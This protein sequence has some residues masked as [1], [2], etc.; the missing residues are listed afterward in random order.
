MNS[1]RLA[2]LS[3][4]LALPSPVKADDVDTKQLTTGISGIG[5]PGLPGT[6][7]VF[8]TEAFTVVAAPSK[9]GGADPVVA[10]GRL[11]K[12][13]VVAFGHEGYFYADALKVADT[14]AFLVNALK[15][16]GRKDGNGLKVATHG[17]PE[18]AK[19]LDGVNVT[20]VGGTTWVDKL[21]GFAVVVVSA[22]R[23]SKAET[24]SLRKFVEA[25]GGLIAGVPGWGWLQVN[26]G[27]T[28]EADFAIQKLFSAAGVA[29]SD[30]TAERPKDGIIPVTGPASTLTNASHALAALD[31]WTSG[32]PTPT[33]AEADLIRGAV[34]RLRGIPETEA[35][36]LRARLAKTLDA[37]APKL[38]VPMPKKPVG[39]KDATGKLLLA[40]STQEAMR[41]HPEETKPHPAAEAFPGSVPADAPRVTRKTTVRLGL[42]GYKCDGVGTSVN[43]RL[44]HSTGLYAAPGELVKVTLPAGAPAGLGVRI[45]SHS[46]TLW[47]LNSW[48][49]APEISREFPLA[50]GNTTPAANPFG[51]LIYIT[52]PPSAE[53]SAVEVTIANAVEAPLFVLGQTTAA[54]WETIRKHPAPWAEFASGKIVIT[55]PS[56]AARKVADPVELM[57]F[58]DAVLD[59]CADLSVVPRERGRAERFVHDVQISAGYMHSGYPIMAPMGEIS[60]V[61]DTA[62]IRRDGAWGYFHELGHNHQSPLWTFDGTVEVTCNLY[63]MYVTEILCPKAQLHEAIRP[64]A[65]IRHAKKYKA[66][67]TKFEA[68]K[69]EPFTALILYKQLRDE[70]GWEAYREAFKAYHNLTAKERPRGDEQ[71]RDEWLLRMSNATGKNL[72]PAFDYWGIPVTRAA[73]ERVA[74]LPAW[75]PTDPT[76]PRTP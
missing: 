3:V 59:R 65:I 28:L 64:D 9:G 5:F 48:Q 25:G 23:V 63:S 55:V 58:W 56:D 57:E 27:K 73:R 18:L 6:I 34:T 4:F 35:A 20:E 43:S 1:M 75:T 15:W 13:R 31:R 66:D 33:A 32:G 41:R 26:P 51:G 16:A 7:C 62:T 2:F 70:F 53:P 12:G 69:Q 49:R 46:D 61:L 68:W 30:G 50:S 10:A 36:P 71:E 45:G 17:L 76:Q 8:G 29:W 40:I 19:S 37:T 52:Y 14:K 47:H 21:D 38:P 60:R 42:Q 24:D 11:G 74:K 44:W 22:G 39:P 67:G 72:A 54:Q